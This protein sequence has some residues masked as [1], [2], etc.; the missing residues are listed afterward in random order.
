MI[1]LLTLDTFSR[2]GGIQQFNRC[3]QLALC[4]YA[5][6]KG[7]ELVHCALMD[8]PGMN[9]SRYGAGSHFTFRGFSN[10]KPAFIRAVPA[11]AA[12]AG[13]VIFGHIN[14]SPLAL[15][16]G[17][18]NTR[19]L[20]MAH[21]IEVWDKLPFLKKYG[22]R[23]MNKVLAVSRF[24]AG[25][26]ESVHGFPAS[27]IVYFPNTLDPFFAE[28]PV[29]PPSEWNRHWR[30]NP[31]GNY[32]LTVA[33]LSHTESAKGYDEVIRALPALSEK[34]PDIAYILAGKADDAEYARVRSLAEGL[35]VGGRLLMPGFVPPQWLPSLYH[36]AR[37]FV[38]PSTKEGFGIVFLEA[39]WFGC[40]VVAYHSGGS[41]EALLDGKTGTLVP[42]GN[43]RDLF[44]AL[45][46]CLSKPD[47]RHITLA[48]NRSLLHARFGFSH[49]CQRL[50]G[51][52]S[53]K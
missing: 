38:L 41:P 40:P 1:L 7:E 26:L 10:Q 14:L 6:D 22:L 49:F 51:I 53:E 18:G 16:P 35:G 48:E 31:R 29:L 39:A 12:R 37:V 27:R 32:L 43:P 46:Q 50:S 24:T 30:I 45:S 20:L 23:R 15:L 28:M 13:T 11:M 36:L 4:R 21:G 3:L 5:E 25:K 44:D 9:D 8:A 33:R 17:F 52:L 47:N 2:T 42:P 19:C 34:F